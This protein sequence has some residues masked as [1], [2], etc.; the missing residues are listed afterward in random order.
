MAHP[1]ERLLPSAEVALAVGPEE[2]GSAI[3][4]TILDEPDW[5]RG[6]GVTLVGYV[7]GLRGSVH[8]GPAAWGG[9]RNRE[10]L[11]AVREAWA[12]LEGQGLL[13]PAEDV[14]GMNGW[15]QLARRASD[16]ATPEGLANFQ[17]AQSLPRQLLHPDLTD[18]AWL[19][20]LRGDYD[21]AVYRAMKRVE[22]RLREASGAGAELL[23]VKLAGIAFNT[24]NGPLTD[25]NA[26]G[27]EKV[28]I[29]NLF[30]GAL[31]AIKNPQSH[32]DVNMD[33]PKEAAAVVMFASYL[34]SVIDSRVARLQQ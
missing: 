15:R 20:F 28:A 29:R 27:G 2:L 4:R 6:A 32:R 8:A 3:V 34:L 11:F 21:N 5:S 30:S 24:E 13:I 26:E 7:D 14:N 9:L 1:L 19:D 18:R 33:E 22:V 17:A 12:W 31:G 10:V 25:R 23:G 16:I